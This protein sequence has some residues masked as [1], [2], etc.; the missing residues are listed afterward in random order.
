MIKGCKRDSTLAHKFSCKESM[1][2][3]IGHND[4]GNRGL[5]SFGSE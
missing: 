5:C 4:G 1:P 3:T 2:E